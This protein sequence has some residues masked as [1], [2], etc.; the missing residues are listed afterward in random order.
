MRYF[1]KRPVAFAAAG[2]LIFIG[3]FGLSRFGLVGPD[4]P[5]Y[6]SIG[7]AMAGTGDWITPRLWGKP[8]FEKPALLYWMDAIGFQA[9][10][11]PELAPRLPVAFLALAFLAFYFWYLREEFNLFVAGAATMLLATS[12]MWI[13]FAHASVTDIPLTVT[14]CAAVLLLLP[15]IE[16]RRA[17]VSG[18]AALLGLSV[19]AKGL[20]PVVLLLPFLWLGRHHWR[21]WL[22]PAPLLVFAGITL[23]W[24]VVCQVRNPQFLSVFFI[25][26]QLG[27]FSSP[28]LRHVQPWWFYLPVLC[29]AFFP[30]SAL[31]LFAFS[32]H[33]Y[34]DRRR[35]FLAALSIWGIV[36]FS[37]SRNKLAGYVLPLLP[38]ICALAGA[39]LDAARELGSRWLAVA[40]AISPLS[41][42]AAPVIV[43]VLPLALSAGLQAA[44]VENRIVDWGLF[45]AVVA[46]AAVGTGSLYAP[47]QRALMAWFLLVCA[48]WVYMEVAALPQVDRLASARNLWSRLPEPKQ[49]FCVGSVSRAWQYG[50]NYYSGNSLPA[51]PPN[52]TSKAIIPGK[53]SALLPLI[54]Q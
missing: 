18:A 27:R 5:R 25:E 53:W 21:S 39:G 3:L 9:G 26:H 37:A 4:E 50:L 1:G 38:L 28:E 44:V 32:P 20:V 35:Q 52:R 33:V 47:R 45:S 48:G 6:A 34:H 16:G 24:Y 10:L 31:A 30:S 13:G 51:C 15:A 22:R 14:F 19:L 17:A 49:A 23:P 8:W 46:A 7:R 29:V 36:F 43:H 2:L 12:A 42:A 40:L 41:L 54:V 11:G